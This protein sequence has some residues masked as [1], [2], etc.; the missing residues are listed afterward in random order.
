MAIGQTRD[1][2]F[3]SQLPDAL[4]CLVGFGDIRNDT[5]PATLDGGLGGD[6]PPDG[7]LINTHRDFN[8]AE[9]PTSLQGSTQR[10]I[11]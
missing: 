8:I 6:C 5:A 11:R 4:L 1:I 2:V 10:G 3:M 7:A 9:S